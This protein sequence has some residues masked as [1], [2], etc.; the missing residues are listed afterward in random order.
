VLR[1]CRQVAA[2]TVETINWDSGIEAR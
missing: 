2:E 1:H